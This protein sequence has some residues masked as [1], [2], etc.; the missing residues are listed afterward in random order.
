MTISRRCFVSGL[1]ALT[2]VF[3]G[4]IVQAQGRT[5]RIVV[6]F[7][8]GG[9]QDILARSLSNELR[10]AL[11]QTVV[12]ENR[13]GAGGMVGAAAVA[14]A[15][16]DGYTLLLVTGAYPAAA[17]LAARPVFDPLKDMTM[18]SMV[19]SY[20]FILNVPA[21]SPHTSFADFLA[22]ARRHPGVLNYASSGVGSIGHL[23]VELLNAM[24]GI[25]TVH[26]PTRGGT[27][28]L[29]EALAGR[30]DFLFE[31][32]TLSLQFIKSGKLRALAATSRDRYPVMP[33]LATVAEAL[34]GYEVVSFIALGVTG[35]TPEPI[36]RYLNSQVRSALAQ[37][38]MSRRLIDLGGEPQAGSVEEI[39][40]FVATE[41]RKW[42][43]VI[44]SRKIERQ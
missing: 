18:V 14:R 24:A 9:V 35:G 25:E 40:R 13:P 28:A 6:P 43:G 42:Q 3:A 12:V 29:S 1:A 32:P 15:K 41:L 23:T 21:Q 22:H 17:A 5:V 8:A 33:E 26:I 10:V 27:T 4:P 34:P 19:T 20:P 30:V 7:A 2:G 36:V 39:N 38:D 11:N 44:D 16:P 37:P 31:A